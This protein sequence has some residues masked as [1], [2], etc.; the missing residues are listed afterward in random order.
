MIVNILKW[1]MWNADLETNE[2][3]LQRNEHQLISGKNEA[4]KKTSGL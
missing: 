2:S 1:Y 3:D 4:W